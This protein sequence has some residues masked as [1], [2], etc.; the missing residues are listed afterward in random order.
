[1]PTGNPTI[2]DLPCQRNLM[3]ELCE[4]A[5]ERGMTVYVVCRPEDMSTRGIYTG[6]KDKDPY[7]LFLR[8]CVAGGADGVS[9]VADEEHLVWSVGNYPQWREF[10]AEWKE[11]RKDFTPVEQKRWTLSRYKLAAEL[12]KARKQSIQE[13][14]PN[15]L[16]YVD[17]ARLLHG[18]DPY[19]IIGHLVDVDYFGCH[20]QPHIVR[21]WIAATKSR[22]VH[23]SDYVRRTV[24]YAI[25]AMLQGARLIGSYRYNYIW[26]IAHSEDQR[27]REN[28]FIEQFVRWGGTRPTR[29]PIAFLVSRASEAWWPA[30]CRNG[31]QPSAQSHR[32]WA[33]P[34]VMYD[35]LLKN[36]YTFDVFYLD[37]V[38]DLDALR[39]YHLVI[40]PF[41]Y[42]IPKAALAPFT[43]AREA[44]TKFLICERKGEVDDIGQRH[45]PPL[46]EDFIAQGTQTGQVRFISRDLL[47]LQH[48]RSYLPE[49]T[50]LIDPLLGKHKDLSLKRH[51]NRTEAIVSAVSPTEQYVSLINWEDRESRIEVG[52]NLPDGQYKLLTLS[53]DKPAVFRKGLLDGRSAF[54]AEELRNFAIGLNGDEVLSL[55]VTP[56]GQPRG[57]R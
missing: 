53:S 7:E 33:V 10:H 23:M 51:G 15:C 46:L 52:L 42:S 6:P 1:M 12:L 36:G 41:A 8:E 24:R 18:G 39:D 31:Q 4:A 25:E 44:G 55:Y 32:S 56:A 21:R 27:V 11:R 17:G 5:H 35:F 26:E 13:V 54:T 34:E 49:M 48:K 9:L 43:L 3:T 16:F 50:A 30:D 19:D 40:V 22:K 47:A 2:E 38:G 28:T 45:A 37:Q 57:Q 14:N 29:A 20:Y